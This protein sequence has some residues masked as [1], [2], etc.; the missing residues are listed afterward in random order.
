MQKLLE[1]IQMPNLKVLSIDDDDCY[2][3]DTL[4]ALFHNHKTPLREMTLEHLNL[5]NHYGPATWHTILTLLGNEMKLR[6]CSLVELRDKPPQ[7]LGFDRSEIKPSTISSF[8]VEDDN[9]EVVKEKL[10]ERAAK[11][12]AE[13]DDPIEEEEAQ[14]SLRIWKK[15][16]RK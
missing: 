2:G 8:K 1:E 15:R 7:F 11:P 10:L 6:K 14:S 9:F 12:I 3:V 13:V 4:T 5:D 16:P